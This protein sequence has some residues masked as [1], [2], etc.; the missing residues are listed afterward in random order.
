MKVSVSRTRKN[1]VVIILSWKKYNV[2]ECFSSSLHSF[3]FP[4]FVVLNRF[5]RY[6][7]MASVLNGDQKLNIK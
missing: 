4:C 5:Q 2:A 1:T 6:F 7:R 3:P